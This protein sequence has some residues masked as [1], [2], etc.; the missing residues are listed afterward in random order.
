VLVAGNI[1]VLVL[2]LALMGQVR[3][4]PLRTQLQSAAVVR[5]AIGVAAFIVLVYAAII[6]LYQM[7]LSYLDHVQPS[8]AAAG[9]HILKNHAPA[10][11]DWSA[12][13]AY[14]MSYGP[15]LYWI[16]GVAMLVLPMI[17]PKLAGG[18]A[19][20]AGFGIVSHLA[21]KMTN[22]S[23]PPILLVA[24]AVAQVAPLQTYAF[25]NRGEPF[26][27]LVA[28]LA[29]LVSTASSSAYAVIGVGLLAGVASGIKI[30]GLLYLLPAG[31][32]VLARANSFREI[33]QLALIGA[34]SGLCI[35][36]LPG[37]LDRSVFTWYPRYLTLTANHGFSRELFLGSLNFAI[38]LALPPLLLFL[39][40]RPILGRQDR[41]FIAGTIFS[42]IAAL[43]F[44]SK[45]GA[46]AHHLLPVV[47]AMLYLTARI[48]AAP[49]R[50]NAGV[51]LRGVVSLIVLAF[52]LAAALPLITMLDQVNYAA[53]GLR[54]LDIAK[55]SEF[56]A[57]LS[58]YPDAET[59]VSDNKTYSDSF[60][61]PLQVMHN[62]KYHLDIAGWMDLQHVGLAETPVLRLIEECVVTD[63]IMPAGAPFSLTNSYNGRPLFSD[64][65]RSRFAERYTARARGKFYTVWHCQSP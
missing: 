18:L 42:L 5:S 33:M 30:H 38:S 13:Q 60:F 10:Y 24:W 40:R 45:A 44:A 56:L 63:W 58:S 4:E 62:G 57:L 25:W 7:H 15:L 61:R 23:A 17:G 8:V 55:R 54:P 53:R 16:N 46:G 59:G 21:W 20:I 49:A 31:L 64:H 34:A 19:L 12:G 35:L 11:P 50:R 48:I 9:W 1:F 14:G 3:R 52:G 2:A 43:V 41:W 28:A 26:L 51:S 29:L 65:F 47:P 32:L 22:K 37:L 39:W 6:V 27:Y 36:V